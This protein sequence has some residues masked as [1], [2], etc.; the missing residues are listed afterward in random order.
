MTQLL[1]LHGALGTKEQFD[2]L[3]AELSKYFKVH[4]LDFEGH[5]KKGATDSAFRIPYFAENVLGYLDEHNINKANIFGYSMGGYVALSMALDNPERVNKIATLGTVLQWDEDTARR[6]CRLLHPDKIKE[7]V[8][9]F[10]QMLDSR[11]PDGWEWVVIQTRSMLEQLG[12]NP[13]IKSGD[14]RYLNHPVRL[15]IGDRD[16]TAKLNET[17]ETYKKLAN[18]G[19]MVLPNTGHPIEE[20]NQELLSVSLRDFFK[21]IQKPGQYDRAQKN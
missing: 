20:V 17:T 11:H 15:H 19:L 21:E 7:K 8:P 3:S 5:G 4:R 6:E 18:A 10:A 14:W 9:N 12:K 1:L 2:E 13:T 16:E